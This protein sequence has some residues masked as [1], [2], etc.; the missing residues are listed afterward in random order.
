M[1][2]KLR[3]SREFC[4]IPA[5]LLLA[6]GAAL[7]TK[8][9]FGLSAVVAPAYL[10]SQIFN[11]SFGTAE[12]CF[13]GLLLIVI[14]LLVGRFRW[15]YLLSFV[16]AFLYGM[17]LDGMLWLLSFTGEWGIVLRLSLMVVAMMLSALGVAL[18]FK[19]YLSPG[20]YELFVKEVSRRFRVDMSRFKVFYDIASC[21]LAVILSLVAFHS[22][23]DHGIGLGTL[24]V[25]AVNGLLIG[26]F[27]RWL[28]RTF[29]FYDRFPLAK[30]FEAPEEK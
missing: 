20:G 13:Q 27:T 9:D 30:Y 24:L 4:Y 11:I 16:S 2:R 29:V 17:T 25:A 23:F 6:L 28:E 12:Y 22:L 5:T 1:N 21:L 3:L 8:A 18:L 26:I 10:I 15:T 19:T 7:M 14:C